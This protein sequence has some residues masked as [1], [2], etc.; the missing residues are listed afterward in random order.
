MYR[1]KRRSRLMNHDERLPVL[2]PFAVEFRD[3]KPIKR[4]YRQFRL[5]GNVQPVSAREL[6]LQPEGERIKAQYA[7]YTQNR[8]EPLAVSDL[9]LRLGQVFVV[10]AVEPW[11]AYSKARMALYDAAREDLEFDTVGLERWALGSPLD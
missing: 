3:G 2:R 8:D 4:G 10:Q 5:L 9:V 6:M 1:L 7:V 11:G